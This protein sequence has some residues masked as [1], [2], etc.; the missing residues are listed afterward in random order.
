[1][2]ANPGGFTTQSCSHAWTITSVS[3][4]PMSIHFSYYGPYSGS[5]YTYYNGIYVL[6][7]NTSVGFNVSSGYNI[8]CSDSVT[9]DNIPSVVAWL[10]SSNQYYNSSSFQ[11]LQGISNL[12]FNFTQY[13]ISRSTVY[14]IYPNKGLLISKNFPSGDSYFTL[15][16]FS[17]NAGYYV[18]YRDYIKTICDNPANYICDANGNLC[19]LDYIT[20]QAQGWL[21]VSPELDIIY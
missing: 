20:G 16:N 15:Y 4:N 1:L 3:S 19:N 5:Y 13:G 6:A 11:Y 14:N 8:L 9:I 12:P 18:I 2:V 10:Y 17:N 7:Q 21:P